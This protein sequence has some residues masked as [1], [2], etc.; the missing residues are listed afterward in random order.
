MSVHQNGYPQE[1]Y[2]SYNSYYYYGH[3]PPPHHQPN[4]GPT[5]Y[6]ESYVNTNYWAEEDES[7][8][9]SCQ[10][11]SP[12]ELTPTPSLCSS[13]DIFEDSQR[14]CQNMDIKPSLRPNPNGPVPVRKKGVGG[15]RKNEK[16]PSPTVMKKRRL[17]ANA[18]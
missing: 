17:A 15:R 10:S 12:G 3:P 5:I 18:R 6:D 11:G 4:H 8:S 7:Y 14:N 13:K 9:S 16:P 1:G 2:S